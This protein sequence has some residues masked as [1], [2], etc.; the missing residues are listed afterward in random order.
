MRP[1]IEKDVKS[2]L[3]FA[4][5]N[6]F[7]NGLKGVKEYK[8]SKSNP[9]PFLADSVLENDNVFKGNA[10]RPNKW[11]NNDLIR[12]NL[13]FD[14]VRPQ[15]I[16]TYYRPHN[17]SWNVK[18]FDKNE[19]VTKVMYYNKLKALRKKIFAEEKELAKGI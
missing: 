16:G 9:N 1:F 18:S 17:F 15:D 5:K 19:V 4:Y 11:K 7:K 13:I 12:E 6:C 3:N 2:K 14:T 10:V 8:L